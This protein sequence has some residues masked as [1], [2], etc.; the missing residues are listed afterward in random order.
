MTQ[1]QIEPLAVTPACL[2]PAA[3][4]VTPMMCQSL[5]EQSKN[6]QLSKCFTKHVINS[7]NFFT[8][9]ASLFSYLASLIFVY[10]RIH[11]P[12]DVGSCG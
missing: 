6:N 3:L 7:V 2:I 8:E 5:G 11:L 1:R 12:I 9:K 4:P 10:N